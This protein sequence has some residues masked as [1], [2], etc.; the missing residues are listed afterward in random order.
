MTQHDMAEWVF[1]V[2]VAFCIFVMIRNS[3]NISTIL[4]LVQ[5]GEKARIDA[6]QELKIT[7]VELAAKAKE[8][9]RLSDAQFDLLG[10]KLDENTILTIKAAEASKEMGEIANSHNEKIKLATEQSAQVNQRLLEQVE[11]RV[12]NKDINLKDTVVEVKRKVEGAINEIRE[13]FSETKN[14]DDK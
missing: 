4:I 1:F 13:T 2:F 8:T 7:T 9:L 3:R 12:R 5:A 14:N 10:R 6:I 11:G